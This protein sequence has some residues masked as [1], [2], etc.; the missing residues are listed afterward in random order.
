[1]KVALVHY[2]LINHRGGERVLEAFSDLFPEADIFTHVIDPNRT[3]AKLRGHKIQ[4]T[5][6]N[7]LP[8]ARQNYKSYLPLMPIAL[9]QLDLREYDLV[10]SSESGPAKGI[11]PRPDALHVC[12]CHSPM[13]YI[14]NMYHDYQAQS[15]FGTRALMP[16]LTHY[17][18]NWDY[19]AAARVDKFIANSHA[20]AA[21]INKYYRR[22][23]EVIPPPVSVD[24]FTPIAADRVSDAY[25]M[26]GELVDY[27]K[28]LLAVE[29][30]NALSK[31]LVVIGG[32]KMLE[33]LRMKAGPTVQ[34]LG[35][36]PFDRLQYY[37]ARARAL[38]F[39]GEEDFGIVPIE[40][41]ASGRPVIA[42]GRGG[43]VDTVIH[44]KTGILFDDPTHQGLAQAIER[45]ENLTFDSSEIRTH[46]EQFN[47]N[48][49]LRSIR[50][51]IDQAM[52]SH[53]GK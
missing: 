12:Y 24:D 22:D 4:T 38:I 37:Y 5:F 6:I 9:E 3:S 50:C 48:R 28:P 45:F 31:P 35:P 30:F 49:F 2:W 33:E 36:Q 8:R 43:A 34:I 32:G 13:R 39:P 23:A 44:E 40:A 7:S 10:I 21:R 11:I 47:Y 41:M 19:S 52:D 27:K 20:V 18:R 26:V 29:T 46:A 53:L 51:H 15:G 14:W 1:M 16:P 17:L 25:L 42:Y